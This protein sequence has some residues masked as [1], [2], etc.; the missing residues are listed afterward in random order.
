MAV[1]KLVIRS[2]RSNKC[3]AK[4]LRVLRVVGAL[5]HVDMVVRVNR[6]LRTELTAEQLDS[7]VGDDL[8]K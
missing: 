1:G 3:R 2:L 8:G 4:E 7:A 6:L 5:A